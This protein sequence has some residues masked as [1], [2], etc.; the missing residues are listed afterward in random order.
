MAS[1]NRIAATLPVAPRSIQ[2]TLRFASKGG[3]RV[4]RNSAY[5]TYMRD[6][7]FAANKHAPAAFLEG[8]LKA[9]V[10]FVLERPKS[11]KKGQ[12]EY[13]PVRP[14][15]DN[16]IKP[17]MDALTTSNWWKDDAQVVTGDITKVYGASGE[18]PCIEIVVSKV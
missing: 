3:V 16:L 5:K 10:T 15:R 6:L 9:D 4:F 2:S 7:V 18:K 8:P 1:S 17:V 12:R 14:D 11:K 13:A